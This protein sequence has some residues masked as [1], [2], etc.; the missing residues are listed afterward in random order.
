MVTSVELV[1]TADVVTSSTILIVDDMV[2][3]IQVLTEILKPEGYQIRKALSGAAALRSATQ[4]PPDLVLLDV[5][6]PDMNGYDVC[7]RFKLDSMLKA[8][9]VVFVSA[10][11]TTED[12][13]RGFE[14]GGVD[15]ISKPFQAAEVLARVHTHLQM[16]CLQKQTER[17]ARLLQEK[18]RQLS[19]EISVRQQAEE[20]YRNIFESASEGIFQSTP[21]GQYITVNPALAEIYGYES[22]EAL[23]ESIEDIA[24]Q[25][26]VQPKRR[27]ELAVYLRQAGKIIDAVSEIYRKDGTRIWITE[28]VREVRNEAGGLQYYEGTIQDI[29]ERVEFERMLKQERQR[30]EHLLLNVLPSSVA[31]RLKRKPDAIADSIEAASVLFADIVN[32]TP[33]AAQTEPKAV[34]T[35]LNDIFSIFDELVGHYGLEKIKTIGDAYMVGANVSSPQPNHLTAIANLALDMQDAVSKFIRPNGQRFKLRIG[36][37]TGPVVAGVIGKKTFAF[38]LWGHTVN[39]AS[40]MEETSAPGKIQVTTDVY[41]DLYKRFEFERRGGISIQGIGFIETYFLGNRL[42]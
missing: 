3:N 38:D 1:N 30:A 37:H 5:N 41:R 40:R 26:Y 12:R 10:L 31:Q 8:I 19:E 35:V 9:P 17:Q 27:L 7:Q 23:T 32:F 18:N 34:V 4:S 28:N 25:I 22:P 13:V 39:I 15:Y 2:D 20:K 42:A 36:F 14:L 21:A 24:R 16:Y 33:F 6:M 11:S 29:T